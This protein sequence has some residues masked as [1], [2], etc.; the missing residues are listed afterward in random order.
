MRAYSLI[1]IEPEYNVLSSSSLQSMPSFNNIAYTHTVNPSPLGLSIRIPKKR[2]RS[3]NNTNYPVTKRSKI[4]NNNN[5]KN[6]NV[7]N[8]YTINL[9]SPEWEE[10]EI[11]NNMR[12]GFVRQRR[13]ARHRSARHRSARHRTVQRRTR[14]F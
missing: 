1:D 9:D 8:V 12:P 10:P 11:P 6:A 5:L 3:F 2:E 7:R 4:N 13:S 14:R